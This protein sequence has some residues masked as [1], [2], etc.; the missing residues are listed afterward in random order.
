MSHT[1]ALGDMFFYYHEHTWT[2]VYFDSVSH[3]HCPVLEYSLE[4]R[5][6]INPQ[7]KINALFPPVFS[8]VHK[9]YSGQ[10]SVF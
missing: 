4:H 8:T 3:T 2:V 10:L 9:N 1:G 6:R 7:L 5:I